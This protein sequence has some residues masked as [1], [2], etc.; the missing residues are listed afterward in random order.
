MSKTRLDEVL[1]V[2][3][4]APGT[5]LW[6]GG[7]TPL[8]CLRGVSAGQAAWKPSPRRHSIWELMLHMAYWKYAV[9]RNLTG[10]A[11]GGF[12]RS[13]SNWPAVPKDIDEKAWKRDRSLLRSEHEAFIKAVRALA[14]K[15]LDEPAR[16]SGVYRLIDLIYG[17]IMHDT[18]HAGQIQI[19][20]RLS[21]PASRK[22]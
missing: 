8:G 20:K 2:L 14:V 9:R 17:I 13:P 22:S 1:H 11:A 16:G 15:R 5:R 19:L 4:P 6:Y 18:Y 3:D 10:S 21:P 7:A 12:P